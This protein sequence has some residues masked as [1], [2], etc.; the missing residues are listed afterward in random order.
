MNWKND[1]TKINLIID[2]I[3]LV[4]LMSIAGMGFLIKY[5]LVPGY[6]RNA[7]YEG[8]VE[9][10]YMG[11]TRH[12]WGNIHLWLSFVF[13]F[14]MI[15]HIILHWKMITC[16]FRQLITSKISRYLIGIFT[17]LLALLFAVAPLF[18]K[19]DVIQL[20]ENHSHK[21]SAN[22]YAEKNHANQNHIYNINEKKVETERLHKNQKENHQKQSNNELEIFGYM[23]LMEVSQK[24]SVQIAEITKALNIPIVES[25]EKIGRLKKH[26]GFEMEELKTIIINIQN[27]Q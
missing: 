4:F 12:E 20:S 5:I 11:L 2:A 1:K 18:V 22:D 9:L 8:D 10:Y 19:P 15:L 16:I 24:Y 27:S 3:M 21:H 13:L 25:N 14:L 23:T 17:G 7:L 26:Y 6:K